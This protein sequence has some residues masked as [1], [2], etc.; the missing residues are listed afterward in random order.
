MTPSYGR[1]QSMQAMPEKY[2]MWLAVK[3]VKEIKAPELK[4]MLLASAREDKNGFSSN[5]EE[6]F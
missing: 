4:M 1:T 5:F 6:H 3:D 2:K